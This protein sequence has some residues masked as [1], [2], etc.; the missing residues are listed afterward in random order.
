M[1]IAIERGDGGVSIMTITD[2][3]FDAQTVE[4]EIA[5]WEQSCL[6]YEKHVDWHVMEPNVELPARDLRDAWKVQDGA[7]ILDN[8]KASGIETQRAE[9]S[10]RADAMEALI[11]AAVD[12]Q[13]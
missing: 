9:A 4:A 3:V 13:K 10:K 1:Q 2:D 11:A 6:E 8:E 12:A 7:V 5:K